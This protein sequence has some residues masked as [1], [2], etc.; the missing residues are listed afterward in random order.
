MLCRHETPIEYASFNSKSLLL[1]NLSSVWKQ[2]LICLSFVDFFFKAVVA[3]S[4]GEAM[5]AASGGEAM[6][7]EGEA[8]AASEGEAAAIEVEA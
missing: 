7:A 5:E 3:V 6:G 2:S 4:E 8:E 1:P